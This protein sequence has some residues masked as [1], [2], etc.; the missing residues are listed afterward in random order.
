MKIL[1]TYYHP[2]IDRKL[3]G[4][5]LERVATRS[6]VLKEQSIL[7][8]YTERYEDYS[9]P[10]GGVDDGEDKITGMIRELNEETGALGIHNIKPFGIYEEYR[11]WHKEK[12]DILHM[13]SYCYTCDIDKNLGEPT[14]ESYEINNGMKAIWINIHKA[15]EHNERTIAT[16]EK[17]GMS[18]ERETYLLK[19]IVEK[20]YNPNPTK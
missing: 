7:L 16:S 10:G 2:K 13:M 5:I 8:M 20:F 19:L 18:I 12:Y 6:I 15:I 3:N 11:P 4:S 17:K 9:L 14:M 1:K